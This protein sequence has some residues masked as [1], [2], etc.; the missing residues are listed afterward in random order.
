MRDASGMLVLGIRGWRLVC[1]E[2]VEAVL[3]YKK[4]CFWSYG[5][6]ACG[7]SNGTTGLKKIRLVYF[8]DLFEGRGEKEQ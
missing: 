4:S 1:K 7:D 2:V 5:N 6:P 8:L 3:N